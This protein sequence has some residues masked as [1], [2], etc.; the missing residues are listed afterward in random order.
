MIPASSIDGAGEHDVPA[1]MESNRRLSCPQISLV[2]WLGC[3]IFFFPLVAISLVQPRPLGPLPAC[4]V[5]TGD[6]LGS[7]SQ[8]HSQVSNPSRQQQSTRFLRTPAAW[9]RC[10]GPAMQHGLRIHR[11]GRIKPSGSNYSKTVLA[12]WLLQRSRSR[13][14]IYMEWKPHFFMLHPNKKSALALEG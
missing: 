13:F 2:W 8:K 10:A 6:R 5:P 1:S 11:S 4:P 12:L 7:F 3:Q 9:T 14:T